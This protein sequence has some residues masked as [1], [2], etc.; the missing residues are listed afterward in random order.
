[1]VAWLIQLASLLGNGKENKPRLASLYCMHAWLNFAFV[2][3]AC[4]SV[5]TCMCAV[6]VYMCV[7]V[8]ACVCV[9]VNT[10]CVCHCEHI[11]HVCH[12][13]HT[14]MISVHTYDGRI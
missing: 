13:V 10:M 11:M 12:C 2:H 4:D 1:M 3:S 14:C 7:T 6:Q 8:Y 9:T 5:C